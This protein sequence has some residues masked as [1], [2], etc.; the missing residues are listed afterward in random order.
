[1]IAFFRRGQSL[2]LK[3]PSMGKSDF[4]KERE[5]T[6]R[7]SRQEQLSKQNDRTFEQQLI[8]MTN[9]LRER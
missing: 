5:S 9:D 2:I 8:P 7:H 4:E 1:M 6:L 3:T